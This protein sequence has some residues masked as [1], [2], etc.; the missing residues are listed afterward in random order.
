MEY[1]HLRFSTLTTGDYNLQLRH[2]DW[3]N[4]HIT[5]WIV[6]HITEYFEQNRCSPTHSET[7][8][9]HTHTHA[10]THARTHNISE[11]TTPTVLPSHEKTPPKVDAEVSDWILAQSLAAGD[12]CG[13]SLLALCDDPFSFFPVVPFLFSVP[14]PSMRETAPFY[15]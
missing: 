2:W 14:C 1:P 5:C 8:H 12:H 13:N 6:G 3:E 7:T 10:R 9:T 15:R 4:L 11:P